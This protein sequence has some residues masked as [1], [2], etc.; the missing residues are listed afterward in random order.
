MN[1][2]SLRCEGVSVRFGALTAV[3][4]VTLD[5]SGEGI[6]SVIGPN[7]AGKTTFLN[8]LSG[9]QR[10]TQGRVLRGER[11]ITG[12]S[13]HQRARE[14]IG[15][16]FQITQV[17]G[18]MTV[19]ENLRLARQAA[20]FRLQPFWRPVESYEALAE[21]AEAVMEEI[22]LTRLRDQP[23]EQL[24]HG[25][26]RALELGITLMTDPA[27]LLLDEPLAGVGEQEI[28]QTMSVI[29]RASRGRTVLLIE[30]NIG[31]V[32]RVSRRVVVLH[33]GAVLA[34]GTPEEIRSNQAVREAYLGG[35]YDA[36]P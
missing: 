31:L 32:M 11:D 20:A 2:A 13:A 35:E 6:Q 26:Q 1:A 22:G 24:S 28:E 12:T 3:D 36:G 15:R 33:Q 17:F 34:A 16:S 10:P 7:G 14:G 8:V 29:T 21:R 5:F 25:D 30:H 23:A 9:R 27:I 18:G 4:D 19:F